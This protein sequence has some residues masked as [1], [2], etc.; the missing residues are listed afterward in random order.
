MPEKK[1]ACK[2]PGTLEF[3]DGKWYCI[4]EKIQSKWKHSRHNKTKKAKKAKR[5][6]GKTKKSKK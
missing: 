6:P 3:L 5:A 1:K 2:S 4:G